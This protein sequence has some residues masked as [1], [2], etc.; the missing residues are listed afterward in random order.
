MDGHIMK[1][2]SLSYDVS[3]EI[4]T[5]RQVKETIHVCMSIYIWSPLLKI[6]FENVRNEYL[7]QWRGFNTRS[8]AQQQQ[9]QAGKYYQMI[10]YFI[11]LIFNAT[12]QL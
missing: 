12:N 2:D 6:N 4:S 1:F 7:L 3:E 8:S 9:Q 10:T 5:K 11:A